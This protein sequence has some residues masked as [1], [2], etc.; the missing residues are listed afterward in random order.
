MKWFLDLFSSTLGRK[1]MMAL[2]GLFLILFLAVHLAGN[3]QL[4][5]DD[6][7][8]SFNIY[9]E[10][11]STN[12]LIQIVSK[13][14][15]AFILIHVIWAIMLTSK[16]KS[17]RGPVGYAEAS[18]KSSHWTSRNMGILGT[19]VLVF[20]VVH[21]KDFWAQ[22]HFGAMPT[23]DY[24]GTSYRDIYSLVN[25]WF[26]VGWYVALYVFCMAAVGFH[27]YHGFAS[28]FQTLGLNHLKYNGLIQVV[29]RAFAIIVP[30]LFAAIPVLM[31]FN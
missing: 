30:L 7:G 19:L 4:L 27:L 14:N 9:A 22:M 12:P 18:G 1:L 20:I 11:M 8:R 31:F 26:N 2:T 24:D 21:L 5:K 6:G 23:V 15:F 16:N 29:G 17:A 10:F 3:L 13:G 28:A 25:E